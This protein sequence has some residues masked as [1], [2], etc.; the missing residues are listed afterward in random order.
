MD[1]QTI[2]K[3]FEVHTPKTVRQMERK[4][5]LRDGAKDFAQLIGRLLPNS[6][7]RTIAIRKTQ[8]A[9]MFAVAAIENNE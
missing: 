3:L 6:A 1:A 5:E 4:Q 9:M 7:E 2:N 8:E